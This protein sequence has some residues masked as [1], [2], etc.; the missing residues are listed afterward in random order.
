MLDGLMVVARG[1]GVVLLAVSRVCLWQNWSE[2][3]DGLAE[4]VEGEEERH[5]A[6]EAQPHHADG[7]AGPCC[8]G[9]YAIR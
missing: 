7:I 1:V 4:C 8:K 9:N 3:L 5:Y 6:E 2:H